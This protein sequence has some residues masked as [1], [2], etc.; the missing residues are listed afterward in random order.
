MPFSCTDCGCYD[1]S[2]KMV[3]RFEKNQYCYHGDI[4]WLVLLK[5]HIHPA[6]M[7]K[8]CWKEINLW[9]MY[10]H[11]QGKYCHIRE[12]HVHNNVANCTMLLH[13]LYMHVIIYSPLLLSIYYWYIIII[14][15]T[16]CY[17]VIIIFG[18]TLAT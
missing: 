1:L 12:F 4:Y 10:K 11:T 6:S 5:S 9:P 14:V 2:R 15:S 16:L 7:I 13:Y 18:T 8:C 17:F 3:Y